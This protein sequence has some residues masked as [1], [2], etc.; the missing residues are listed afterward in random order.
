MHILAH[1]KLKWQRISG[2]KLL[3]TLLALL[4]WFMVIALGSVVS[5]FTNK[6]LT[7]T[8]LGNVLQHAAPLGI[9][10]VGESFC[11]LVGYFDLAVE[12]TLV[13]SCLLGAWLIANHPLASGLQANPYVGIVAILACGAL[14]GIFQGLLIVKVKAN[15]Y[16]TTLALMVLVYGAAISATKGANIFPM[17][18]A[19]RAIAVSRIASIPTSVILLI[20]VYVASHLFLT[21]TPW[22]RFI[23]ATGGNK[24]AARAS[25]V[26]T[27]RVMIM[28]FAISGLLAAL[29][30]VLISGRLNT[31]G[32]G[33]ST[34]AI[35]EIIAAAVIGGVLLT[36]GKGNILA[37][38][39]GVLLMTM[40]SNVL[41]ILDFP[42]Y[43]VDAV[44]GTIILM[45]AL[46]DTVRSRVG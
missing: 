22:G 41:A 11:L 7:P 9:M 3:D 45:A 46:V 5:L 29:A 38:F 27:D 33:L 19:Y 40:V 10:V 16:I 1:A 2:R 32:V 42:P 34:G 21:R 14:L 8:N 31:V 13:L 26:D 25:G 15:S 23:Y 18:K 39:G 43:T 44:R 6:F 35:F 24:A 36:G 20:A 17:P 37:A 12:S 4:P 30:G 28:A